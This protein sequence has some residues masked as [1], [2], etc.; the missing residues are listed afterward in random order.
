MSEHEERER[1]REK[2]TL[3]VSALIRDGEKY[4]VTRTDKFDFWRPPGGRVDWGERLEDC[5]RREMREELG[6]GIEIVK[7][8]GFG[9]DRVIHRIFD[10]KTHRIIIYFLCKAKEKITSFSDEEEPGAKMKW[11]SL[12]ELL[13]TEDFEPAFR[14]M[15]KRFNPDMK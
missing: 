7:T 11:V 6:V 12:E 10:Y 3:V 13:N 1:K 9:E 8:L 14:D 15:F 4:L 5:L 2:P